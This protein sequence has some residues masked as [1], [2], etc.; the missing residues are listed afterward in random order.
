MDRH[1]RR[2]GTA[3]DGVRTGVRTNAAAT[4]STWR[5]EPELGFLFDHVLV[6]SCHGDEKLFL[7]SAGIN[8]HLCIASSTKLRKQRKIGV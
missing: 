3:A 5:L 4:H 7:E 6:I 8:H 1:S 2:T